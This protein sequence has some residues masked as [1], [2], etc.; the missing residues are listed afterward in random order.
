MDLSAGATLDLHVHTSASDGRHPVDVVLARYLAAGVGV[1]AVTDH[2]WPSLDRTHRIAG[3]GRSLWA[4]AAAELSGTFEGTELHL[5]AYFPGAVPAGFRA[6]CDDLCRARVDRYEAARRALPGDL[7]PAGELVRTGGRALTRT[8]LARALVRSGQ[9]RDVREAFARHLGDAQRKV[10]PV[11]VSFLEVLAAARAH[12]AFTSWAH[13]PVG[14]LERALP[15][16]V[17]AGLQGLEGDRPELPAEDR[18]RIR[19]AAERFGLWTTAGSDWHGWTD[20][21]DLGL[22]RVEA[23]RLRPFLAEFGPAVAAAPPVE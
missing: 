9:V 12:G 11:A 23:A 10:P 7:P 20:D 16:F 21:A 4:I 3:D 5:L 1:V 8:H 17:A 2:D 19:R 18:R 22:F 13:P 6:L 15:T 14:L